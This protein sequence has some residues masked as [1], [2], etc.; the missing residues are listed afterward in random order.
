MPRTLKLPRADGSL[1][2][3]T[4]RE[5]RMWPAPTAPIRSRVAYAAAHVV[6][7][8]HSDAAVD[9]DATLA[10]RRHLWSLGLGVAEAMDTAQRGMGLDWPLA[11]ELI[12]RSVAEARAVDGLIACG[13]G[14]DQLA[15]DAGV[16]L[17]DVERAYAEQVGHVEE[18]GG[19]VVLM[20]SRA[21]A[22]AGRGPDDY[23]R[24]YGT[25]LRQVRRP[26]ILHWLGDMFDPQLT[27]YW[28]TSDMR[29][30]MDV[31]LEIIAEHRGKVDGIKI[32]LLDPNLEIEMRA[33]MPQGVRMYTGDDFNYDRLILGENGVHSDALL[34]IFDAI[35]PAASAA[36]QALDRGDVAGYR[37]VLAPTVPLSRH[38]FE[39]PTYAYKTGIVFLAYLNG[40]QEHFRMLAGAE[41]GRDEFH[42]A[43]L[44]RLA[45]TAGLLADPERA[46]QRMERV[47]TWTRSR[48]SV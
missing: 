46:V 2:P 28:G 1:A 29:A 36:L 7:D 31:C 9:W 40:H 12:S 43:E 45:D 34:G 19:R 16:T 42:L 44:F 14:T 30:A 6:S 33:R 22:R 17:D 27:G 21:L 37:V 4:V 35:A 20:A 26:V 23:R 48:A 18:Q 39:P 11:R 5:P 3:Y 25:I 32:S 10:Y 15:P 24:A 8:P 38:I 41:S 47:L 13:A